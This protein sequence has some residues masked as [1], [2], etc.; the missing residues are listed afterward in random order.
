M[1]QRLYPGDIVSFEGLTSGHLNGCQ[2]V[3]VE[4]VRPTAATDELRGCQSGEQ[5]YT[6]AGLMQELAFATEESPHAVG[7]S[8]GVVSS[9]RDRFVLVWISQI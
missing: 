2:A 5:C 9:A 8:R 3:I 4:G 1:D 6:K 7:R